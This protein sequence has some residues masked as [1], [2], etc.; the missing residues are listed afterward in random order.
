MARQC[1][2]TAGQDVILTQA[3]D[4]R[5]SCDGGRH[6]G[7]LID[8]VWM[9][10][11]ETTRDSSP[12]NSIYGLQ[13]AQRSLRKDEFVSRWVEETLKKSSASRLLGGDDDNDV[14]P[15][16]YGTVPFGEQGTAGRFSGEQDGQ[17]MQSITTVQYM[18]VSFLGLVILL[19]N[20]SI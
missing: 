11:A 3:Q 12:Y 15:S 7:I 10:S 1:H 5:N 8:S 9:H 20:F 17:Q 13:D 6:G 19:L 4:T 14:D 2:T 18:M 16:A